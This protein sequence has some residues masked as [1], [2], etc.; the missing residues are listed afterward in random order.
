MTAAPATL[1]GRWMALPG[2]LR[3]AVWMILSGLG[4]TVMAVLIKLLGGR[5]DSLQIAFFRCLIGFLAILPIALA[6][7]PGRLRT[8]HFPVHLTRGLFGMLA[9]IC[10]YYAI[11]HLPLAAYTALSFSKPLFATVLAVLLLHEIVRWRRW[12][13][14]AL[15]FLGVLVMVRPGAGAFDPAA[16]VALGDSVSIAF[17]VV[18]VKRLPPSETAL[19]MLFHFGIVSSLASLP[20]AILVWRPPSW[21]EYGLLA[22][23]GILGAAAQTCWIRA[24]RAGEASAVAPFDYT[25]LIFAAAAGLL[26]FAEAPDGWTFAGAGIIVASTLYIARRESRLARGGS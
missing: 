12:S 13:A 24:F 14:T 10:S 5:L 21:E 19:T 15:G 23:I 16:L 17:L 2:N 18:L 11:Q 9:M 6:M 22:A 4:F 25:R 8:R 26:L 20:L 7:G 1:A 3:G